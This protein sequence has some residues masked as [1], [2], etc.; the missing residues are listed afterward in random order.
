M[1][2]NANDIISL[3]PGRAFREKIGMYLSADRQ[4]AINLGLREL[5]VNVQD[6]FEVY[7]PENPLLKIELFLIR[8][9]FVS[10]IICVVFQAPLEMMVSTH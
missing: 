7:K 3:S 5:I 4:E 9:L 8:I 10:V 1:S 2:Y 6:E